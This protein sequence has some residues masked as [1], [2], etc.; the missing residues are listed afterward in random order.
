VVLHSDQDRSALKVHSLSPCGAG[1]QD[2][3]LEP[4]WGSHS[5]PS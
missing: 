4:V 5:W 2:L 3:Q 1:A